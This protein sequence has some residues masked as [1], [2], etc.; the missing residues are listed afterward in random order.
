MKANADSTLLDSINQYEFLD[1]NLSIVYLIYT[2]LAHTIFEDHQN[3]EHQ[4]HGVLVHIIFVLF[5]HYITSIYTHF[6][7]IMALDI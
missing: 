3:Q 1:S 4:F 6:D 5:Q 2:L 7:L